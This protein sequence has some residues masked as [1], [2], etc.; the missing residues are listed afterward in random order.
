MR[1]KPPAGVEPATI[2]LQGGDF[3]CPLT[4]RRLCQLSYDGI[5]EDSHVQVM[6]I[7]YKILEKT[8][9]NE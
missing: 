7:F 4:M 1:A 9:S 8:C 6:K 2:R 5:V 3:W